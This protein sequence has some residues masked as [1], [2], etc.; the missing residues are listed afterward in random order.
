MENFKKT[1]FIQEKR[2]NKNKNEFKKRRTRKINYSIIEY[3]YLDI[4]LN[5][6]LFCKL[7]ILKIIIIMSL[8][9]TLIFKTTTS[10]VAFQLPIS[11]I[12]QVPPDT[13]VLDNGST[14]Y[15]S[16]LDEYLSTSSTQSPLTEELFDI[17]YKPTA[18]YNSSN[19]TSH[20]HHHQLA[21][22]VSNSKLIIKLFD[23]EKEEAPLI[24]T[25]TSNYINSNRTRE[26]FIDTNH[27]STPTTGNN[28]KFSH[29]V[30]NSSIETTPTPRE[31]SSTTPKPI[32][33]HWQVKSLL[34]VTQDYP[35]AYSQIICGYVWPLMAL[36]TCF[37]N[38][39]IVF[40]L[41]QKDMRTPTN[42]VLTA[43]AIA[44]IIPIV[45]P[46]P[47][48]VYLFAMG[49][50]KQ[51]LYPPVVCY[52][53][54]HSTR[55]VSEI[56]YFLSTWLNVLLA[57]QDYLTACRPKLAKR[58][59]QINVVIWEIILLTLLAFLLNLPQALKLV[60]KPIKFY[61]QGE[62]TW[63]CRALQ[64]KW[65]KDLIGEYVALYDDIFTAV[66]VL[67][68]DGGPAI[69]LITLSALLIRQLHKQRIKGHKLMEQ[70][71]T[72]SK[73]RLERYRQQEYESSARVMI[74]V[75]LAFLA[76]KIPFATTYTLMI[77]QSRFEIHIVENLVDFQKAISITDLVFVLSYPI[78]FTIFCCCSKKFRHKCI[79]LFGECNHN[80]KQA[81]DRFMGSFSGS[82]QYTNNT[83]DGGSILSKL[84]R[85]TSAQTIAR[86]GS[87]AS[88]TIPNNNMTSSTAT[89]YNNLVGNNLS[90]DKDRIVGRSLATIKGSTAN[91]SSNTFADSIPDATNNNNE[92]ENE[93]ENDNANGNGKGGLICD[94][95]NHLADMRNLMTTNRNS[96]T[97]K[98]KQQTPLLLPMDFK[99]QLED[100][101]ICLECIMRYEQVRRLSERSLESAASLSMAPTQSAQVTEVALVRRQSNDSEASWP[102]PIAPPPL[103]PPLSTNYIAQYQQLPHII[104]TRCE[105]IREQDS[106]EG[107]DW[108]ARMNQRAGYNEHDLKA[109]KQ[110]SDSIT[111]ISGQ[112]HDLSSSAAAAEQQLTT[113]RHSTDAAG[114]KKRKQDREILQPEVVTTTEADKEQKKS[115][116][117]QKQIDEATLRLTRL[118]N[119]NIDNN[120]GNNNS[121]SL[122]RGNS[123]PGNG[124]SL[125]ENIRYNLSAF[126]RRASGNSC[127]SADTNTINTT[128]AAAAAAGDQLSDCVMEIYNEDG[129][130]S[131]EK[132]KSPRKTKREGPTTND[133]NNK[134]VYQLS[135]DSEHESDQQQQQQQKQQKERI[136]NDNNKKYKQ[137]HRLSSISAPSKANSRKNLK[138]S[139]GSLLECSQKR[140]L[141][142]SDSKLTTL[143]NATGLLAD[144]MLTTLLGS[145]KSQAKVSEP[146]DSACSSF[147]NIGS[148]KNRD[149]KRIKKSREKMANEHGTESD[150]N[151]QQQQQQMGQHS[152]H[153][154]EH[155]HQHHGKE[156]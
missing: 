31:N 56:F 70:A 126:I 11:P 127:T 134:N 153:Q 47:W 58:W 89:L 97:T 118:L 14:T 50:E 57:V 154:H 132:F 46:V 129:R 138:E 81:R 22:E 123:D 115:I 28:R 5:R 146:D 52:F 92:N 112:S 27:S 120:H 111:S 125:L 68:V 141:S 88:S 9:S 95:R 7:I 69:A 63:G 20:L 150:E 147:S 137:Q 121:T 124:G 65:F 35:L 156:K 53:Y 91:N 99:A 74:F 116:E 139:K 41:T 8:F 83:A 155:K 43:I 113:A 145:T 133:N 82:F 93:N 87:I 80:T 85:R 79:Q 76:V 45:V 34:N 104:T 21:S 30:L 17:N 55:S 101:S 110:Q 102:A 143:P 98:M 151:Q 122:L 140:S 29:T 105:S 12:R 84:S 1:V 94:G 62:L 128:T 39:M 37:T 60:F 3:F 72:A 78:N 4:K 114:E 71:R 61:Y 117:R 152:R 40:V 144:I 36:I 6:N 107:G 18:S 96:N 90:L 136:N 130:I 42:V 33:Q 108:E 23:L 119:N 19:S 38:L 2:I 49:N 59:C 142:M 13:I 67:F 26:L 86:N 48:F 16:T 106:F 25:T 135:M 100:G 15:A 148:K 131:G 66:I 64:A 24:R 73:R 32:P 44:D 77:I 75:L 54:Q 103:P 149:K 51:V 109:V 10:I